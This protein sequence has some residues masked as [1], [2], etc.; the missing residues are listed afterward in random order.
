MYTIRKVFKFEA[1][2]R[3]ASAYSKDC[4]DI[5]GHSYVVEVF[6]SAEELDENGMVVDFGLISHCLKDYFEEWDH[7][8]IVQ[9]EEVEDSTAARIKEMVWNANPTAENMAEQMY[10]EIKYLISGDDE[11]SKLRKVRVH[12]TATGYAEY[13][14]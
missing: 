5:H 9:E 12:E 13:S 2:H 10:V 6:L 8:Y 4:M 7:A 14:E 1:A 3:L 11:T